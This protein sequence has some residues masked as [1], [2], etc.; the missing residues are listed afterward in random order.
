MSTIDKFPACN[1]ANYATS[2][3]KQEDEENVYVIKKFNGRYTETIE[4]NFSKQ[5][6]K[7][8]LSR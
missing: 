3:T 5:L 6:S 7:F 1:L 8:K 4:C 2:I